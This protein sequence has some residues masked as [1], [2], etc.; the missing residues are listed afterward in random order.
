M[1]RTL[2][3]TVLAL[4]CVAAG[5]AAHAADLPTG[6]IRILVPFGAGGTTDLLARQL[7]EGMR[8][9]L[10]QPVVVE[11]RPGAGGTIAATQVAKAQPDG[12]TLLLGTPG[13]Q[14]T[15]KY[16]MAKPGYDVSRDFAPVIHVADAAGVVLAH[17]RTGLRTVADLVKAARE[18]PGQ[19][20]WASPGMGSTGHLAAEMFQHLSGARLSHVPYK[21]G[22]QVNT[23][24]LAGVVDVGVDNIPTAQPHI[25][26]GKLVALGTTGLQPEAALPGVEPVTRTLSGFNLV[27]WFVLVAPAAT[28]AATV[29][30]LNRVA[31][32]VMKQP[33]FAERMKALGARAGGGTPQAAADLIRSEE[34]KLRTLIERAGLKPE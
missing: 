22:A 9:E 19:V 30:E 4:A 31:D 8:R 10:N 26:A 6:T 21:S 25:Q 11:N 15:N 16:L 17:P 7:A 32:K 29:A 23:D 2:I 33:E 34:G 18:R 1:L 3:R 27:S 20:T 24:I 12:A 13:T 28:P 5:A 14:V